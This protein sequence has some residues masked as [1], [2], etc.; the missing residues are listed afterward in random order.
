[1]S[2]FGGRGGGVGKVWGRCCDDLAAV[3]DTDID[4]GTWG[5]DVEGSN[6]SLTVVAVGLGWE[7]I[8]SREVRGRLAVYC[9]KDGASCPGNFEAG[10]GV[11]ICSGCDGLFFG[12]G[13]CILAAC[14]DE[15]EVGSCG[16]EEA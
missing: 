4:V 1:M 7:V 9:C 12:A 8:G 5:R 2:R 15:E 3:A 13:I 14:P 6:C 11:V 16:R 10:C